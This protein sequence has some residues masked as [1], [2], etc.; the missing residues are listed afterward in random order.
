MA[1][2]ANYP[3]MKFNFKAYQSVSELNRLRGLLHAGDILDQW[4]SQF[5]SELMPSSIILLK[6]N[7]IKDSCIKKNPYYKKAKKRG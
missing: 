6:F 3:K 2:K 4:A 1:L 5:N 7:A